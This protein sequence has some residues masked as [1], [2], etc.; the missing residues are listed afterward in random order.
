MDVPEVKSRPEQ[1]PI[2][3]SSPKAPKIGDRI[4]LAAKEPKK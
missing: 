3:F 1:T 4:V 2:G